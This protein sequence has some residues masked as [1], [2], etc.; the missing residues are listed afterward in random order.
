[1]RVAAAAPAT[2]VAEGRRVTQHS[3]MANDDGDT[4]LPPPTPFLAGCLLLSCK[5][6]SLLLFLLS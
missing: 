6:A 5:I 4:K 1:M 2:Q 3:G